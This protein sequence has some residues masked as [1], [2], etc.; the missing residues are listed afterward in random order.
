MKLLKFKSLNFSSNTFVL[1]LSP[2]SKIWLTDFVRLLLKSILR[3]YSISLLLFFLSFSYCR[4][5]FLT[6]LN[7]HLDN[8]YIVSFYL[9]FSRHQVILFI[10]FPPLNWLIYFICKVIFVLLL[11]WDMILF[12]STGLELFMSIDAFR[13]AILMPRHLQC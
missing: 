13:L 10:I 4:C 1:L 7:L 3:W 6:T 5:S 11:V 8:Y 2:I 9:N 12:S